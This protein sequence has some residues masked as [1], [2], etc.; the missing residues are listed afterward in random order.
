MQFRFWSA[1][2]ICLGVSINSSAQQQSAS[3]TPPIEILKIK[4][5]KQVRLPRN[6]D[7]SV[8]PANGTFGDPRNSLGPTVAVGAPTNAADVTRAAT[9][10]RN[11]AAEAENVF[12]AM[13]R[14][15]PVF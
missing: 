15:L 13:P 3:S 2:F 8:I 6:F 11:D 12:P 9:K 14:R 5:E 7:P 4:W 1:F 10:A